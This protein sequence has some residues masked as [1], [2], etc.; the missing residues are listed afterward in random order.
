MDYANM[1]PI[2]GVKA[3][4]EEQFETN[5]ETVTLEEM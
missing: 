3:Q 5:I 1:L 2:F 4:V